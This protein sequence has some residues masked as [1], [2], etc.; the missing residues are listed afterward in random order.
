M[1]GWSAIEQDILQPRF[2]C[3]GNCVDVGERNLAR[4]AGGDV[5]SE[6]NLG[7]KRLGRPLF[8]PGAD[9]QEARLILRHTLTLGRA[10]SR[11]RYGCCR[12]LISA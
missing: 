7:S 2:H 6:A 4:E 5:G 10:A 12:S 1:L 11:G 9:D 3:R 8:D